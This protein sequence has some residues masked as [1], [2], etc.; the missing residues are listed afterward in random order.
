MSVRAS[1]K[2]KDD[3]YKWDEAMCGYILKD[4]A[5]SQDLFPVP[6]E[7]VVYAPDPTNG[8]GLEV[9]FLI[10]TV[11]DYHDLLSIADAE[12]SVSAATA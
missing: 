1:V 12:E 5:A 3:T 9:G 8:T 6:E 2:I 11:H 10:D 4:H 7:G